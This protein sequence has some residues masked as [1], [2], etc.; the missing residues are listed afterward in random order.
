MVAAEFDDKGPAGQG[1]T[2]TVHAIP[3]AMTAGRTM[4]G[5]GGWAGRNGQD[6]GHTT[7]DGGCAAG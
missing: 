1:V 2:M 3:A 4:A 5:R 7:A 6:A